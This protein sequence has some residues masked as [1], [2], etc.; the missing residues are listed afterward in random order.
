MPGLRRHGEAATGPRAVNETGIAMCGPN[1]LVD[2]ARRY[3]WPLASSLPP[4][5]PVET[6]P[7]CGR[8]HA[9]AMLGEWRLGYLADDATLLV[10][11]LMT[12]AVKASRH[13]GT[14]IILRLLSDGDQ[15]IIEVWDR[16]PARPQTRPADDGDEDGRGM[17][18]VQALSHRTGCF[19]T[20]EWK[21]VWCELRASVRSWDR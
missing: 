1:T 20:G 8:D 21:V 18:V 13:E 9:R 14:P 10:S 7:A 16:N 3:G 19:L 2:N 15:L 11:E 5:G 4:L 12:N 17:Q 6:A